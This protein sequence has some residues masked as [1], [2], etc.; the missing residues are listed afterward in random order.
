MHKSSFPIFLNDSIKRVVDVLGALAILT[1]ALPVMLSLALVIRLS[2]PGPSIY[3]QRRLTRGGKVFTMF[4]F[5]TMSQTAE[6]KSGAVLAQ[7]NDTRIT[8]F[9]KFLRKFRLD[10]LPQVI[11]VMIGDM[12]L[13]GPRPERP[14][15]A[16]QLSVE[17]P[18]MKKRLEVNAGLTGLAQVQAGYASDIDSYKEKLK[19]DITYV[20][21]RSLLLDLKIAIRTIK[22]VLTGD[23]A[24]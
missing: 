5:R 2:S 23:G 11:N 10:E 8:P 24:R 9:G 21:N 1:F 17:L 6:E 19:W 16:R 12:S 15:I 18:D 14:E 20:E 7:K 22:V 3:L 13:I 4:K